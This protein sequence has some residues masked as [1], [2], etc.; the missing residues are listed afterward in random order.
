[1]NKSTEFNIKN[2]LRSPERTNDEK[3]K[4]LRHSEMLLNA[5]RKISKADSLSDVLNA[6]VEI[7]AKESGAEWVT[8]FLLDNRTKELYSKAI[9][10]GTSREIRIF[11]D[12]GIA[13]H[14]FQSETSLI[15]EDVYSHE[16]FDNSIDKVTGMVTKNILAFPIRKLNGEIIGVCEAINKRYGEFTEEN[17][18]V[19]NTLATQMA[20][21]LETAMFIEQVDA[22]KAD[23]RDFLNVVSDITSEINLSA[24]LRKVMSE[25][26]RLLDAERSTLFLN[27]EKTNELWSEV[28]EGLQMAEIRIPNNMGIAGA[29][30]TNNETINIP[31]AYADLRFNPAVDKKTGFF[32]KSILCVPVVNK[33]GKTIGAT[34]VLN[35]YG[36][37]FT[38][39]DEQRLKAFSAHVSIGLENAKLFADVQNMKNYNESML[40]SMSNGVVTINENGQ[41]ITCNSA[42]QQILK[43]TSKDIIFKQADDFFMDQNA[44]V[45][46]RIRLVEE[47]QEPETV[48][49]ATL[50][51]HE[52]K[53]SINLT[54]MPLMTVNKERLGVMLMM[55]DITSEKRVKSTM[56]KYMD[57]SIV[58]QLLT[59]DEGILGGQSAE[60]TILFSDIRNFT[61]ITEEL[62]AQNTVSL[63]NEYFTLMVECIQHEGGMLD[64]FIGD[65]IMAAFGI[66]IAHGDDADR[67]VRTAISMIQSLVKWNIERAAQKKPPIDMGIGLNT[68]HIVSGN[69]GSPKRMDFTMIGDGV[70]L[71]SRLESA[72]K[73]YS[74]KIL[75]SEN[76]YKKLHGTYRIRE[77]DRVIVKGK[78]KPVGVYE[79]L[80]YHSETSFPNLMEAVGFFNKAQEYYRMQE[81]DKATKSFKEASKLNPNDSLTDLYL[82][83]CAYLKLNQPDENWDGVWVMTSK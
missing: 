51:F 54:V 44:W 32:T 33:S 21:S 42:I 5:Y 64:K 48:M 28:G 2:D 69:I 12:Q 11:N 8:I 15:I 81:W 66:P 63:L 16:L 68:D 17:H 60:A 41:I 29:V 7:M 50:R 4:R 39:D 30:F 6:M 57:S 31:Y 73:Q 59:E 75:F 22:E 24:V 83:R 36:G 19:L 27:D 38:K 74:T 47:S 55:D 56:A 53:I 52:T 79:V 46:D 37:A 67:A 71:A 10:G 13:G 23:E 78:T 58:D 35:K 65:S 9:Y 76:T 43:I 49:D 20:K 70:N 61:T 14:V 45:M 34:Q 80:D 77:I 82:N 25:T 72:C 3:G 18:E 62:G 1:M 26:T 40:D